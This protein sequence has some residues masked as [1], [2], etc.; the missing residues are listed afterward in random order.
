MQ[1]L[2]VL[3]RRVGGLWYTFP[4]PT[5]AVP[6]LPVPNTV[7]CL[8]NPIG[9]LAEVRVMGMGES[10][11]K[12]LIATDSYSSQGDVQ[13]LHS[14]RFTPTQDPLPDVLAI[15]GGM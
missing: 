2:P 14:I 3:G 5:T 12:N 7:P 10:L 15:V 8:R 6:C 13:G 9:A 4:S 11:P 1:T